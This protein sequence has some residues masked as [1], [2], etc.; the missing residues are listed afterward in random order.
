MKQRGFTL[1]EVL[2]AL[3][4]LAVALAAAIKGISSHVGNISY[5]KERSLAHWVGMNALTELRVSGRYPSAG[6]IKGDESMAGREF[7]WVIKVTEVEGGDVRRLD[8][9]VV[10]EN[11]PERPLTS[12][13]AYIGKP[14]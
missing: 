10:P 4:I 3:A 12:L 5:L 7:S 1:L 14:A 13:I 9:R 2:I 8:V 11:D 6:E